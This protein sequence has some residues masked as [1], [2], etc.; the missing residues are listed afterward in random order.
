MAKKDK[1]FDVVSEN[2]IREDF[3][4]ADPIVEVPPTVVSRARF[5]SLITVEKYLRSKN[6]PQ[7]HMLAKIAY[8]KSK[9]YSDKATVPEWDSLFSE[10]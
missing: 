10:Y 1:T 4:I 9:G 3:V 2:T 5:V 8:A 6:V 7:K